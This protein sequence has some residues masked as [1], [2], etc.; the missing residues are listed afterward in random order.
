[1]GKTHEAARIYYCNGQCGNRCTEPQESGATADKLR[2]KE[3]EL[4][5]R[6]TGQDTAHR[7]KK[8]FSQLEHDLRV[9]EERWRAVFSNPFMGVTVLD[10]DQYFTMTSPT[11]QAMVGYTDDELKRLTPL[12]IT[13]DSDDREINKTL[14]RELQQGKRQHFE[15]VKRLQRKDGKL[16]WIQLYVFRI[17]D[18]SS[19]QHTFGMAF[20]ITEKM[21]AQNALQAAQAE[22]VRSAHVSRMGAMTASIAHEI[23]QPLGAILANANAG[24]RWMARTPPDLTE[25]RESFER[26]VREGQHVSDVIQSVRSMF[27]S[28]EV[29]RASIDLN[30]LIHEVLA[31]A[32][33]ALQNHGVVVRTELDEMLVPVTGNRVQLQQVLFNLITNAIEAMESVAERVMLVKSERE[34]AGEVLVTV[35]DSGSGINQGNVDQI[36]ETFFTT[37]TDGMGMG[38]SI[39][40]SI[41]ESHGGRLWASPGHLRGAVF[42]FTLPTGASR[43]Y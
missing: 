20:D 43:R 40:R 8:S 35:E 25:A 7:E 39:C 21:Q 37:K 41:I 13:P 10:K 28:K 14:F 27:K 33:G 16:I 38:L 36:F 17:P 30:Q 23:N 22:L 4:E 32:G 12:D 29:A 15:L 24:L 3:E 9:N 19:G 1:L 34:S 6:M 26:I 5:L 2:V 42:R 11:F 31:L 18:G